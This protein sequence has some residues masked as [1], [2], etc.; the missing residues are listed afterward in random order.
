M[1]DAECLS[2][3]PTFRLIGTE[4]I[5]RR[6]V[7]LTSRLESFGTDLL[8]KE[9]NVAGLARINRELIGKVEAVDSGWESAPTNNFTRGWIRCLW[10]SCLSEKS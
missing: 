6:G 3:D 4:K 7:A 1:N 8:A 2:L 5:W 10:N 9:E